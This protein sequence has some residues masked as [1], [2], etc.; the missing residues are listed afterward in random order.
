MIQ[1]QGGMPWKKCLAEMWLKDR[2]GSSTPDNNTRVVR[3]TKHNEPLVSTS[4]EH[5]VVFSSLLS[6]W[7][8]AS[9]SWQQVK[10]VPF[11]D[12]FAYSFSQISAHVIPGFFGKTSDCIE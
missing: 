2:P 7:G 11:A 6:I 10:D 9:P 12:Y 3:I 4:I 8:V 5:F 1:M